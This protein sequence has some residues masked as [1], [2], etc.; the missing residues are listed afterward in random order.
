MAMYMSTLDCRDMLSACVC[1]WTKETD[2]FG[3]DIPRGH[4]RN[5]S[6]LIRVTNHPTTSHQSRTDVAKH[7]ITAGGTHSL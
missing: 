3:A 7:L 5:K 6:L 2:C 4:E 1:V